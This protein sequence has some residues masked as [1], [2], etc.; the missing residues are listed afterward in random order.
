NLNEAQ[1]IDSAV[2]Y[3]LEDA[4]DRFVNEYRDLMRRLADL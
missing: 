4:V 2:F 1:G 3:D